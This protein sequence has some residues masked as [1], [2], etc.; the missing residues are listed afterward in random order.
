M[1]FPHLASYLVLGKELQLTTPETKVL[2][3]GS[4]CFLPIVLLL[5]V[6]P[7]PREVVHVHAPLVRR[8]AVNA[9]KGFA[10]VSKEAGTEVA[11]TILH[12]AITLWELVSPY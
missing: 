1:L 6:S 9:G 3:L 12:Q 2:G 11:K 8:E 5:H 4:S 7:G 10:R